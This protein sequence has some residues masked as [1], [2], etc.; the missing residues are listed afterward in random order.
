MRRSVALPTLALSFLL[1]YLFCSK[2]PAGPDKQRDELRPRGSITGVVVD[3]WGKPVRDVLVDIDSG[4]GTPGSTDRDGR[5][6]IQEALD[7]VTLRFIH[8]DYSDSSFRVHVPE[9]G[10]ILLD[11]TVTLS[12][13]WLIIEGTISGGGHSV[14]G[15]GV[16]VAGYTEAT[17]SGLGG[18]FLLTRVPVQDTVTLISAFGGVGSIVKSFTGLKD[19]DT[20]SVDVLELRSA[21]AVVSGY[22]YNAS[23]ESVANATVQAVGGAISTRTDATGYYRLLNVPADNNGV[24]IVAEAA[25]N[26]GRI[27]GFRATDGAYISGCDIRLGAGDQ[28]QHGI[29]LMATDIYAGSTAKS[30]VVRVYPSVD[31]NA[32]IDSYIWNIGG[33]EYTTN[34]PELDI[35]AS[36]ISATTEV[37]VGAVNQDGVTTSPV[38]F[39]L[40]VADTKT[41]IDSISVSDGR[42][43]AD[44]VAIIRG[45]WIDFSVYLTQ[46][47]GGI[48]EMR[49]DFGD[50][51]S[52]T[53]PDSNPS[54]GYLY[55]ATGTFRARFSATDTRSRKVTDTV[56]VV[57]KEP[58]FSAPVYLTASHSDTLRTSGDS[59]T[60]V[61]QPVGVSGVTY[62]VYLDW[63]VNRPTTVIVRNLTDT[64]FTFEAD[65]GRTYYWQVEAVRSSDGKTVRGPVSRIVTFTNI[66]NTPPRFITAPADFPTLMTVGE[67]KRDTLRAEDTDT[68][69]SGLSYRIAAGFSGMSI[70]DSI[71]LMEPDEADT[72]RHNIILVVDDGFGG[73]DSL[74]FTVTVSDS[75]YAPKFSAP[76][77]SAPDTLYYGQILRDTLSAA[78][79][80]G[81]PLTFT[82]IDSIDGLQMEDSIF[83]FTAS[84]ELFGQVRARFTVCD[85]QGACDTTTREIHIV[86]RS[87]LFT[88]SDA[89]M[90]AAGFTGKEYCDTLHATDSDGDSIRFAFVEFPEGMTLVDSI[91][92]WIPGTTDKGDFEVS[93]SVSDGIDSSILSWTIRV[94]QVPVF[95]RQP[96]A[97][98]VT[99]GQAF[100]LSAGAV[101]DSLHFKWQKNGGTISGA[102]DSV[103]RVVQATTDHAGL[104][105]CIVYNSMGAD[106]SDTARLTVNE[107]V[108][109][110]VYVKADA[111]VGGDGSSWEKAFCD[112]QDGING[113]A[114]S[115]QVWVAAGVYKPDTT[116]KG[117]SASFS[118]KDG[119]E[120]YGGFAGTE[121]ALSQR[122]WQTN[123]TILSGDIGEEGDSTDNCYHVIHNPSNLG[124]TSS[125]LLDG[126]MV[127]GGNAFSSY[128]GGMY[129]DG[130]WP[131]VRNCAFESNAAYSYG[132]AMYNT[133]GSQVRVE[134]TVFKGNRSL[135]AA[136]G[137]GGGAVYCASSN[138]TFIACVFE[139]NTAR[140]YG[141]AVYATGSIVTIDRCRFTNNQSVAGG[142][143]CFQN[144]SL[145][146]IKASSFSNNQATTGGG[147]YF[148]S[149]GGEIIRCTFHNN[150]SSDTQAKGGGVCLK[151][152]T[153]LVSACTFQN[154]LSV[155]GGAV[156]LYSG[157]P[158]LV[159]CTMSGNQATA[160]GG[161]V[162]LQTSKARVVNNIFW[163]NNVGG[164]LNDFGFFSTVDSLFLFNNIMQ[165]PVA[166]SAKTIDSGTVTGDP[167]LSS[168]ADNGG[169]V[170]TFALDA[171]S[172]ALDIGVYV[173]KDIDDRLFYNKDGGT[174]Y[175]TIEDG[176][177]YTPRG[178]PARVNGVDARGVTRPKGEGIDLGAYER[179]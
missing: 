160:A 48:S 41:T 42:R 173:Y 158:G 83:T 177:A 176:K 19:N 93:V 112:V 115:N 91:I 156:M 81:D 86:N 72:G 94:T 68:I 146:S 79:R 153:T 122:N 164:D 55:D 80:N 76:L 20:N 84:R 98:T 43:S 58:P 139:A 49:W 138:V 103:Y 47:F 123:K 90:L 75:N 36:A 67:S 30:V 144:S 113:A 127:S 132:G 126:F 15:A 151:A 135:A 117:Q 3:K 169:E 107:F 155:Y 161:A 170:L 159:N 167:L 31:V 116:G 102:T 147:I 82:I 65:S 4:K 38:T 14:T 52:W 59:V 149:C 56:I 39:S 8:R 69:N 64:T 60:L 62:T 124:I 179:E 2:E 101:G 71:L 148:N 110:V 12:W 37:S 74:K 162:C 34:L 131:V 89:E 145:P 32:A 171:G 16:A 54:L 29:T 129:N 137:L 119:V 78:D 73:G 114:R 174:I 141:G 24:L 18:Q 10:D 106:T 45:Q 168:L 50:G 104:Y 26:R 70:R 109:T 97:V 44:S 33:K 27:T 108:A 133:G 61:W 13:R 35:P 7:S 142:A 130:A 100:T 66:R 77:D 28:P 95:I 92:T 9:G 85:P 154:N 134:N 63:T 17:L 53:A 96:S 22:V 51:N 128:G 99:A 57:V 105:S 120:V 143:I 178:T 175:L 140:E 5:F 88:S 87:P 25:G 152:S 166:S 21:G 40:R 157:A 125:A 136:A 1:L 23:G 11:D 118:M 46:V 6:V 172:P 165:Q 111:D 121:T 150:R 163:G